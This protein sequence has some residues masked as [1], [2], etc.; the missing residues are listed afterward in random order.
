M[1]CCSIS[2]SWEANSQ[3]AS[4]EI[5]RL[6]WNPKVN[7]HVDKS[8]L[9][10]PYVTVCNKLFFYGEELLVPCQPPSWRT[11]LFYSSSSISRNEVEGVTLFQSTQFL[12]ALFFILH[13]ILISI[14]WKY[15]SLVDKAN[16]E[17]KGIYLI[18]HFRPK[19]SEIHTYLGSSSLT[20]KL[21]K[22]IKVFFFTFL[23]CIFLWLVPFSH[24]MIDRKFT[25]SD[26]CFI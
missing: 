17:Q 19:T 18:K 9:P 3:P 23:L 24:V 7:Y 25:K 14:H 5:P 10:W 22:N 2:P 6:L 15:E 21:Y 1:L 12:N 20:W 8:M 4:Q 16:Q 26:L 13:G 11:R